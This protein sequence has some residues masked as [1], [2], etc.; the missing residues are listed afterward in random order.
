MPLLPPPPPDDL[1]PWAVGHPGSQAS[2]SWTASVSGPLVFLGLLPL[3]GDTTLGSFPEREPGPFESLPAARFRGWIQDSGLE[4]VLQGSEGAQTLDPGGACPPRTACSGWACPLPGA[5]ESFPA[6]S[7]GRF[8]E[9]LLSSGLHLPGSTLWSPI[10]GWAPW[11]LPT[12]RF[13]LFLC[14]LGNSFKLVSEP[15][16][17]SRSRSA[18]LLWFSAGSFFEE[19]I[20]VPRL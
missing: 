17:R 7:S 9:L 8:L 19:R 16:F 3:L 10:Q 4:L 18:E 20:L 12:S 6:S 1:R 11:R 13:R 5:R 2:H 15:C 14:F